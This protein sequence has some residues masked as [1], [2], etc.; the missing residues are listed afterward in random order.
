[1]DKNY[2]GVAKNGTLERSDGQTF[3]TPFAVVHVTGSEVNG[4][5]FWEGKLSSTTQHVLNEGLRGEAH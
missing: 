2:A 5:R 1:M 4:W 3:Q